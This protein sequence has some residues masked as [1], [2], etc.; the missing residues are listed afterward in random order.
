[1]P[2]TT[3]HLGHSPRGVASQRHGP[4]RLA[5]LARLRPGRARRDRPLPGADPRRRRHGRQRSVGAVAGAQAH[6]R[7]RRR[8]GGAVR[9][10]RGGVGAR[11]RLADRLRLLHRELEAAG[12]RGPLPHGLQ[13]GHPRAPPRPAERVGRAHPLRRPPRLAGAAPGAEAHGGVDG[14]DRGQPADDVH[15]R[16]QLR[17]P[18]RDR[19]RRAGP[20]RCRRR[21]VAGDREGDQGQPLRPRDAR[22][23]PR[24]PHLRNFLLCELA[25]SELLFTDVLWP[26]FRRRHLFDAVRE[27]QQR[28]RRFG[29]V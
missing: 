25:Y 8:R 18:G 2:S 11:A 15:D 29:S 20:R 16:L 7:P 27:F 26:D 12:R 6:R 22:P 3:R 1:V 24:H 13:R 17:R 28:E 9:R 5:R 10:R 21:L 4:P 14:A 23:R 19:R